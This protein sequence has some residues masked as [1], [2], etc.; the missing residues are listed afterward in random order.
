ME[1]LVE[2]G[3]VKN[4][5]PSF[6]FKPMSFNFL[7]HRKA[8]AIAYAIVLAIGTIVVAARH[9]K[10]YGIDFT[11]GDEITVKFDGKI[12]ID[13]IENVAAKNDFAE[14]N[15]VYQK[16]SSDGTEVL[17]VQT[18]EGMGT[19]FFQCLHKAFPDANLSL[20]K[21]TEIGAAVGHGIRMNALISIALSMVGVMLYVRLRFEAAYGVGAVASTLLGTVTSVVL[22]LAMGH[23]ISAPMVA[24]I[25]MVVGYAI[26]DTIIVFDRI[27]EEL[28]TRRERPMETVVNIAINKTFARTMLTSSSTFLA[29]LALYVFAS[30]VIVDFALV[31]MVGI[32]VGTISSIFVASPVF[33][34]W[35]KGHGRVPTKVGQSPRF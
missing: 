24:S 11:G 6:R 23:Q 16:S 13:G 15:A 5:I 21:K 28:R 29:A 22:Y 4:L 14:V 20:L 30:G 26:N 27:R 8:V 9:T 7:A 12:S 32:A 31:F 10:V 33:L 17:R 19:R 2:R 25:L 34:A 18:E 35:H 3:I 1:I